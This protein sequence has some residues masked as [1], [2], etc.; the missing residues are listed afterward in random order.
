MK[1]DFFSFFSSFFL[2][3]YK[4][5]QPYTCYNTFITVLTFRNRVNHEGAFFR[6]EWLN[7]VIDCN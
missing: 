1:A 7:G 3:K 4:N 2:A 6:A 5:I